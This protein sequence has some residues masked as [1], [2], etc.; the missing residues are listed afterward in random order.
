MIK[1]NIRRYATNFCIF[2]T[3]SRPFHKFFVEIWQYLEFNE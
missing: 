3:F 2:L 1:S